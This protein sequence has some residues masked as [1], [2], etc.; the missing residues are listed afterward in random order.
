MPELTK[1]FDRVSPIS[2]SCQSLLKNTPRNSLQVCWVTTELILPDVV[3][4]MSTI[5]S[6]G[7]G[8][9]MSVLER[10]RALE[11]KCG[12]AKPA[13]T[14]KVAKTSRSPSSNFVSSKV[15]NTAEAGS[16]G[17]PQPHSTAATSRDA[18]KMAPRASRYASIARLLDDA[19]SSTVEPKPA[20][21]VTEWPSSAETGPA[22]KNPSSSSTNKPNTTTKLS[23]D[24]KIVSDKT[25]NH[26]PKTYAKR[27]SSSSSNS[28]KLNNS[29][30]TTP[31]FLTRAVASWN[32]TE[33]YFD[34]LDSDPSSSSDSNGNDDDVSDDDSDCSAAS[35]NCTGSTHTSVTNSFT[36]ASSVTSTTTG[37]DATAN[38]SGTGT[39][40]SVD[41]EMDADQAVSSESEDDDDELS[42]YSGAMLGSSRSS[43]VGI[44][45]RPVSIDSPPQVIR[46]KMPRH[47]SSGTGTG[48]ELN[49]HGYQSSD[50]ETA[51]HDN[52][53]AGNRAAKLRSRSISSSA[54]NSATI[55]ETSTS[56]FPEMLVGYDDEV[57][58]GTMR[59]V[60]S[61]SVVSSSSSSSATSN[62]SVD[63]T[64]ATVTRRP[65]DISTT[66][67][68]VTTDTKTSAR[69]T[70][71]SSLTEDYDTTKM[72]PL[73]QCRLEDMRLRQKLMKELMHREQ[74]VAAASS[75][76]PTISA[77][78]RTNLPTKMHR[79]VVAGEEDWSKDFADDAFVAFDDDI[80]GRSEI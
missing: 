40:G 32:K 35:T 48:G 31:A 6:A 21:D 17:A 43:R 2:V 41:A 12:D 22:N 50:D 28:K 76:T 38:S 78:R 18:T 10:A 49:F 45:T 19:D 30:N 52:T 3:T 79:Q 75:S 60:A 5:S 66:T 11:A 62:G 33:K 42:G 67:R 37:G 59:G 14:N 44:S 8:R 26:K 56:L 80:F 61:K 46:S 51:V 13:A 53:T 47:Q 55:D 70:T 16:D 77:P 39:R 64:K 25:K 69:T 74:D 68:V 57:P 15:G 63:S 24:E 58:L 9:P 1:N 29:S 73:W 23:L 27:P 20:Q 54:D 71:T 65:A 4:T 72:K 36:A 7:S 34:P